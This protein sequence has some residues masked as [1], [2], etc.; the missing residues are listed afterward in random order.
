MLRILF[1]ILIPTILILIAN[2]F[3]KSGYNVDYVPK[4]LILVNAGVSFI[5]LFM[6]RMFVRWLFEK[7]LQIGN[8]WPN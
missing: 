3:Y 7:G 5:G 1:A 6:F 8:Q 2:V 4:E